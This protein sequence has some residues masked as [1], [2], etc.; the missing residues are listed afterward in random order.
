MEEWTM[1][2][3][4]EKESLEKLKALCGIPEEIEHKIIDIYNYMAKEKAG[5]I[6]LEFEDGIK[7]ICKI[8]ASKWKDA[9]K[10]NLDDVLKGDK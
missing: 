10:I 3:K 7:M 9:P 8:D 2:C 6:V 4:F 1:E 5:K